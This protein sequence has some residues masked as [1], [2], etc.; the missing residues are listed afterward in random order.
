MEGLGGGTARGAVE[1]LGGGACA[2]ACGRRRSFPRPPPARP[3][4][5]SS[6]LYRYSR[7]HLLP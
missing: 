3:Q 4:A 5:L 1:G 6:T 2:L 7:F